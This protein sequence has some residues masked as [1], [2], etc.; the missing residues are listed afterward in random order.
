M[1]EVARYESPVNKT[2]RLQRE[3]A[4]RLLKQCRIS[5][6]R[7][8]R[9]EVRRPE[10]HEKTVTTGI[11]TTLKFTQRDRSM[12]QLA[13]ATGEVIDVAESPKGPAVT[14]LLDK[15]CEAL[16]GVKRVR[17]LHS[18]LRVVE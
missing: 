5:F 6:P 11:G 14:V 7:G 13:G 18:A 17:L 12:T 2:A 16:G 9:V 15:A 8:V 1:A 10:G 3:H 4:E